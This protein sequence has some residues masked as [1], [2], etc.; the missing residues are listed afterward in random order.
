MKQDKA[1]WCRAIFDFVFALNAVVLIS[2]QH[3]MICVYL[4]RDVMFRYNN[5]FIY[6]YNCIYIYMYLFIPIEDNKETAG[7]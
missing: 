3:Q 6:I 2:L 1:S 4:R 7:V 5:V